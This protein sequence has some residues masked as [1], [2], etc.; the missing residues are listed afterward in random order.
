MAN[1]DYPAPEVITSDNYINITTSETTVLTSREQTVLFLNED[2][3]IN[4]MGTEIPGSSPQ[5]T[6][7]APQVSPGTPLDLTS[8]APLPPMSSLMPP[9]M[10]SP[11]MMQHNMMSPPHS[12]YASSSPPGQEYQVSPPAPG[13]TNTSPTTALN[14]L[15][16]PLS[17]PSVQ[18]VLSASNGVRYTQQM[19]RDVLD[20]ALNSIIPFNPSQ[21]PPDIQQENV[22]GGNEVYLQ[23][24]QENYLLLEELNRMAPAPGQ[25][26]LSAEQPPAFLEVVPP[27]NSATQNG[28][29]RKNRE[30]P[31]TVVPSYKRSRTHTSIGAMGQAI[32]GLEGE[33]V[34]VCP[35]CRWVARTKNPYRHLQDHLGRPLVD[36]DYFHKTLSTIIFTARTHFKEHLVRDLPQ[37]KPYYCPSKECEVRLF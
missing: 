37:T 35:L 6:V 8:L 31:E 28:F 29:K 26:Q 7:S 20:N 36:V 27:Q 34:Q 4:T 21:S 14:S 3:T 30:S 16:S 11:D 2:G 24:N 12:G 5:Y 17:P 9:H 19:P 10:M 23:Q 1:L 25:F 22:G 18:N 15:R 13:Y 32:H 33:K